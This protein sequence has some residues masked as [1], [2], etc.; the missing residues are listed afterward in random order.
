MAYVAFLLVTIAIAV[1]YFGS[2][3]LARIPK[4]SRHSSFDFETCEYL[5][6]LR[7]Q[8]VIERDFEVA[9]VDGWSVGRPFSLHGDVMPIECA[10]DDG[11]DFGKRT[12]LYIYPS[13]DWFQQSRIG[14][15]RAFEKGGCECRVTLPYQIARHLLEDIRRDANQLVSI[16]FKKALGKNGETTYPIYSLELSEPLD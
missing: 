2:E 11:P 9:F 4:Q 14:Y 13:S 3:I 6:L 7:L 5:V 8:T 16:R 10:T 12:S 1:V 15:V